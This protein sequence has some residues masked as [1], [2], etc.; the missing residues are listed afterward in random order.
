M[1]Y[2]HNYVISQL[3]DFISDV[4]AAPSGGRRLPAAAAGPRSRALSVQCRGPGPLQNKNSTSSSQ[5]TQCRNS[6]NVILDISTDCVS[7]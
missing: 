1:L 4:T 6:L 7:Q 2:D 5:V 3:G